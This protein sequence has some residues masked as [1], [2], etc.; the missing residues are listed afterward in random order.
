MQAVGNSGAINSYQN[1]KS[2]P[3]SRAA[4]GISVQAAN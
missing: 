2:R 3:V 1:E 4:F